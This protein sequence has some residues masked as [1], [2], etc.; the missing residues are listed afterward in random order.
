[1]KWDR[2]ATIVL[3]ILNKQPE[4]EKQILEAAVCFL[5]RVKEFKQNRA[6]DLFL[7]GSAGSHGSL[8]VDLDPPC[9]RQQVI[10]AR[11]CK[12]IAR[13]ERQAIPFHFR[14]EPRT[15]RRHFLLCLH[16]AYIRPV[17]RRRRPQRTSRDS[18]K[19]PLPY[20]KIPATIYPEIGSCSSGR[21]VIKTPV[22]ISYADSQP[23]RFT[24]EHAREFPCYRDM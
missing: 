5:A 17:C 15:R 6:R 13:N 8:H 23:D 24:I 3:T 21:A 2:H 1:M 9:C 20:A 7:R 12:P 22:C 16:S 11:I 19:L 4:Q 14:F 10:S 18:G